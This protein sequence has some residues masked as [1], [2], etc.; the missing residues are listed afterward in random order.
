MCR[1]CYLLFNWRCYGSFVRLFE[2]T[3]NVIT[4][5]QLISIWF[6]IEYKENQYSSYLSNMRK[7]MNN[8]TSIESI[9]SWLWLSPKLGVFPISVEFSL[10]LLTGPL[11]TSVVELY[12]IVISSFVWCSIP[13]IWSSKW[14]F[15]ILPSSTEFGSSK[16]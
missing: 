3:I 1:R 10:S 6:V 4:N 7:K 16:I 15:W 13:V 14:L 2:V 12:S 9:S 5:H 8:K 11:C